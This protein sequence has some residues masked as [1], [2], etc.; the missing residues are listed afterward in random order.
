[1]KGG[2]E[3][4]MERLMTMIIV[5]LGVF[6]AQADDSY[7]YWMVDAAS[8]GAFDYSAVKVKAVSSDP[9]S[10][11]YLALYYGNSNPVGVGD[12]AFSVGRSD[13]VNAA[14]YGIGFYAGLSQL[15][16]TSYSYVVELWNDGVVA[17][18]QTI[19]YSEAAVK[20]IAS[21]GGAGITPW[22]AGGFSAAP[23]PNSA[24]LLL[25]GCAALALRRKK[26]EELS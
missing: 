12:A 13:V 8:A 20:H 9:G 26:V 23:E 3:K 17:Q 14:D 15:F 11:S 10:E 24:V 19:T 1:M 25:L 18:S 21:L 7:L 2:T 6:A 16:G 5:A 4:V 22:M